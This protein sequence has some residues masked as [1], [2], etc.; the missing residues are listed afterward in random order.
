MAG[1]KFFKKFFDGSFPEGPI[2]AG[3]TL[4]LSPGVV[5]EK[6][7]KNRNEILSLLR[8][9]F[10]MSLAD[11]ASKLGISEKELKEIE[12]SHEL[13]PFQMVPTLADIFDVDLRLL[14]V[15]LGHAKEREEN[16]LKREFADL[17]IAA[18]YSGPEL[19]EQEKVDLEN[20]IKMILEKI[21]K[22]KGNEGEMGV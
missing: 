13:V 12:T 5:V 17:P 11:M 18:Q 4:G 14:L 2:E 8:I 20:L 15:L 3:Q 21:K 22:K 9:Y 1:S 7:L 10:K 6:Y 16:G 19:S